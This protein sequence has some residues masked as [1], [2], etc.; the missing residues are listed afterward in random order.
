MGNSFKIWL[1][2]G[3]NWLLLGIFS[4]YLGHR[5][6]LGKPSVHQLSGDCIS[7]VL[8]SLSFHTPEFVAVFFIA[9]IC[10]MNFGPV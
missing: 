8:K 9:F 1:A 7:L 2:M 6:K 4:S 10:I 3:R 5:D